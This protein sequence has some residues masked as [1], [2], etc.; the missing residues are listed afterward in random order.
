MKAS[1][2]REL[3]SKIDTDV[4]TDEEI[5]KKLHDYKINNETIQENILGK[6]SDKVSDIFGT[7]KGGPLRRIMSIVSELSHAVPSFAYLILICILIYGLVMMSYKD[8]KNYNSDHTTS[9]TARSF[10]D[11]TPNKA[12]A[13]NESNIIN[14][15]SNKVD[16]ET[17]HSDATDNSVPVDNE[18]GNTDITEEAATS[19]S[20]TETDNRATNTGDDS[21]YVVTDHSAETLN[22][23][24]LYYK[25][26]T[27][28]EDLKIYLKY[29]DASK[30]KSLFI[31]S[32]GTVNKTNYII[33]GNII[34]IR[35][36]YLDTL[37]EGEYTLSIHMDKGNPATTRIIVHPEEEESEFGF[38][39]LS[40][41]YWD[42]YL[43][44]PKDLSFIVSN[45]K[46]ATITGLRNGSVDI[47]PKYYKIDECGYVA[48]LYQSYMTGMENGVRFDL[49]VVFSD[50]MEKK[51]GIKIRNKEV[52]PMT[53]NPAYSIFEKSKPED[54]A[55]K[56]T[57]N[58]SKYI[59][60]VDR[61]THYSV[62]LSSK[63]YTLLNDKFTIKK[64]FLGSLDAGEYTW[65]LWDDNEIGTE[66]KVKVN[67][68]RVIK[69]SQI[70]EKTLYL[71]KGEV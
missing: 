39:Y 22:I 7:R 62:E 28:R 12:A 24:S 63:D 55:I 36:E 1:M 17:Y 27:Y 23:T 25:N 40:S 21:H 59:T 51:I 66:I 14:S 53:V 41:Y 3:L 43:T 70:K 13:N 45:C 6:K 37:P 16:S 5:I 34:T 15:E 31:E 42:F 56:I 61:E 11:D 33:D 71:M 47:D 8:N 32:L 44:D 68:Q 64:E 35:K 20:D 46:D 49:T 48:T 54:I 69:V 38:Y 26:D 19:D 4:S 29:N 30:V 18:N 2:Y 58:D 10:T 60:Y 52:N 9:D 57:W 65:I 50:G 67:D